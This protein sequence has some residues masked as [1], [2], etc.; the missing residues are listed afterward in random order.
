MYLGHFVCVYIR[1]VSHLCI[2]KSLVIIKMVQAQGYISGIVS[3]DF[4]TSFPSKGS[5]PSF[6][7]RA[8]TPPCLKKKDEGISYLQSLQGD[9][10]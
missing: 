1:D 5:F 2:N 8:I 9:L 10:K 7:C 6:A 3:V 4:K